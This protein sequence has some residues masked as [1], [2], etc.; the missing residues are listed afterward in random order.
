MAKQLIT[1]VQNDIAV[2]SFKESRILDERNVQAVAAELNKLIDDEYRIKMILNL[3]NVQYLS[4]AVI[5]RIAA[6]YKRI[7]AENGELKLCHVR[8]EILDIFKVTNLDK[9]FDIQPTLENA[10]S[11]F[12][13]WRPE[14]KP[15]DG[16][17]AGQGDSK[18]GGLWGLFKK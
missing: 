12:K 18:K 14:K 3:E 1:T 7:K 5:G 15:A 17:A 6:L 11:R 13:T 8:K 2:V 10:L 16:N 9:V 4:S